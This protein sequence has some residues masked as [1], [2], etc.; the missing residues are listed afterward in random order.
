MPIELV[1]SE[2]IE[3]AFNIDFNTIFAVTYR[4]AIVT[5]LIVFVIKWLGNKGLGRLGSI[6]I[7]IIL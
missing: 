2:I 3:N 1:V 7:I 4:T 5:L 6:E